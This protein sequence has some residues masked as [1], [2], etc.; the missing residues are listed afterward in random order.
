MLQHGALYFPVLASLGDELEA[1][2]PRLPDGSS[3]LDRL[4]AWRRW[5]LLRCTTFVSCW[6]C[7]LTESAAMWGMYTARGQGIAVKS[8]L[9]ALSD[10]F[11]LADDEAPANLLSAG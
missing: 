4:H 11:P 3:E 7:A 2:R 9:D 5:N 1:A 8:T 6:H 10:A